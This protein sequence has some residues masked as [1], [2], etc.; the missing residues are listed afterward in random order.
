VR[1]LSACERILGRSA[2]AALACLLLT[3]LLT[4]PL[5]ARLGSSLPA[6]AGDLWQN[7]W[8]F[9]WWGVAL[10]EGTSPWWTPYLFHPEGAGLA[11]HTHSPL[12]MLVFARWFE[13][14][15]AYGLCVLVSTWLSAFGT[16]LLARELSGSARAGLVAGLVFA[17]FPHRM[18][19]TLE[20]LN[21]FSTQFLPLALWAFVVLSR[22]GG[23]R[24]VLALGA[25]FA[26]NA[27]CDWQ[28]AI[29]GALLLVALA[30]AAWLRQARPRAQLARDWALAGALA[31]LLVLPAAWPL[32]RGMASGAPYQK[33]AVEKG[34]DLAFLLRP[35]F[36]HPLWGGL[37][38][39]AY[40]ERRAYPSAG[41]VS[42]LGVVPLA[43]AGLALAR[44]RPGS[45]LWSGV[46][47]G[48]LLLALGAHPRFEGR[49]LEGVTLPFAWLGEVPLLSALRVANRFLVPAGLALAVLAALGLAASSRRSDASFAFVLALVA[50]D[51]LWLP[52]PLR[53][54]RP[55][56]VYALLRDGGPGGAVLDIPFTMGPGAAEDMRVQVVH[57]RP[58]AGG[59]VSVPSLAALDAIRREPALADLQGFAPPLARPLDRE[60]LAALGFGVVLL[61]KDRRAGWP[62]P[63]GEDASL[64]GASLSRLG[65]MPDASFRAARRRLEQACGRPFFEDDRVAAFSLRKPPP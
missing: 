14:Q 39:D 51:Y 38:R 62:A 9:W 60:R 4:W 36:H 15:T 29:K 5:A 11:F 13:P 1:Q 25:C 2:F 42:Y 10:R 34:A 47:L 19:Q 24:F 52:Y 58:I 54:E 12:N 61:H 40:L 26:A 35:H 20:H 46:F 50:L 45:A 44:R 31:A 41:F 48:S 18:E 7:L 32:L 65:E 16:Y 33:V 27:L 6:G 30:L 64:L 3:L 8:N 55:S 37:T 23:R 56:A 22:R 21:L 53:E 57:G 28:L 63:S 17:F 59:Y 49:L 43:L